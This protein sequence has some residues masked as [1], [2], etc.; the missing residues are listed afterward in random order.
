MNVDRWLICHYFFFLSPLS[1]VLIY[2]TEK[3]SDTFPIITLD[4]Q[5]ITNRLKHVNNNIFS[6]ANLF[7]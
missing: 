3:K 5:L 4:I 2:L 7:K 1:F 6:I